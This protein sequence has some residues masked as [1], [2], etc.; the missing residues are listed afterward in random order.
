MC[1]EDTKHLPYN[2]HFSRTHN[3]HASMSSGHFALNGGVTSSAL[4]LPLAG[5]EAMEEAQA[6]AENR[7]LRQKLESKAQ[8][9]LIL[10]RELEKLRRQ[11]EEYRELPE[12]LQQGKKCGGGGLFPT[13]LGSGGLGASGELRIRWVSRRGRCSGPTLLQL[14]S[15]YYVLQRSLRLATSRGAQG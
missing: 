5:G 14:E 12:R 3:S 11:G 6:A 13:T 9:L 10:S 8:A 4:G 15:Y 7:I 2:K 1:R